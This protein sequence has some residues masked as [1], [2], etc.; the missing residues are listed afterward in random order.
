VAGVER[1]LDP[2]TMA[3]IARAQRLINERVAGVSKA[4]SGVEPRLRELSASILGDPSPATAFEKMTGT[5]IPPRSEPELPEDLDLITFGDGVESLADV[6]MQAFRRSTRPAKFPES[7]T[8]YRGD[9][10]RG[11]LETLPSPKYD[12]K[13]P[14][15]KFE[16]PGQ[17]TMPEER[18]ELIKNLYTYA[19][20]NGAAKGAGL[21]SIDP[22]TLGALFIKEGRADAGFNSFQPQA[23]PDLAFR[24]RLDSE[25]NMSREQKDFLG[26]INYAQRIAAKKDVPFEAVWNGLGRSEWTGKTGYD[27]ADTIS[28]HRKAFADPKNSGFRK[29]VMDAYSTGV[30][31]KIPTIAERLRDIDP[32]YK[33][34]PEYRYHAIGGRLKGSTR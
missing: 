19:R 17:Q 7:V 27:Y 33:S 34:D 15:A 2:A 30:K 6:R 21:P 24:K 28:A 25:F 31:T 9:E 26:M 13:S 5:Y 14:L 16:S 3:R 20:W 12:P 11:G 18:A 8:I 4:A 1:P 29:Y 22:E 10:K 23:A 32:Y